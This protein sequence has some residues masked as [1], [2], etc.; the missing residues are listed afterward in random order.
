MQRRTPDTRSCH[1]VSLDIGIHVLTASLIYHFTTRAF[2]RTSSKTPPIYKKSSDIHLYP[3]S[4]PYDI[5]PLMDSGERS[6][7]LRCGNYYGIDSYIKCLKLSPTT[8]RTDLKAIVCVCRNPIVKSLDK[9]SG[10][11]E[12]FQLTPI[13]TN[14]G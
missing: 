10:L 11:L 3:I 12:S 6:I 14:V 7:G 13:A 1:L 5:L 9:P 8:R 2:D 4:S